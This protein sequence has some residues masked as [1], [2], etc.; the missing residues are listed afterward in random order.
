MRPWRILWKTEALILAV[1]VGC[2][3]TSPAVRLESGAG[4]RLLVHFPRTAAAEPVEVRPE[5]VTQALQRL[6]REVRLSGTPRETVE[7]LFQL[8]VL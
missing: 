3:A 1:L 8:D 7:Q 2:S 4:D 6:A 5:E